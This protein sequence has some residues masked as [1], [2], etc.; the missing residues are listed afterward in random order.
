MWCYNI[1]DENKNVIYAGTSGTF[2]ESVVNLESWYE[3]N[4]DVMCEYKIYMLD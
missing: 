4:L 2:R 1:L 3:N